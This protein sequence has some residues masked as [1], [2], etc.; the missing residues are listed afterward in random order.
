LLAGAVDE[1]EGE[2]ALVEKA[3]LAVAPHLVGDVH[4]ITAEPF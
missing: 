3:T 1:A 4:A 2:S